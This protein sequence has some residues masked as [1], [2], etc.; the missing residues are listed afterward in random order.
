[1]KLSLD[2]PPKVAA[3]LSTLD[4]D[5]DVEAVVLQLIDHAQQGVYRPGAWERGWI[6]QA[7]GSDF[8]IRLEPGDP[9]GRAE[10]DHL[11]QRPKNPL[12]GVAG[13]KGP[14]K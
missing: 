6:E 11:F 10:C 14:A 2:I 9:F 13:P 7:F 12:S 8:Q 4:E 3:L 1:M 5:G